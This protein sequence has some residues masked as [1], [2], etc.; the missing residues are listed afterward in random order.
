MI[1]RYFFCTGC[2]HFPPNTAQ[3]ML[4][5]IRDVWNVNNRIKLW[6]DIAYRG[7]IIFIEREKNIGC[8]V[9]IEYKNLTV[10]AAKTKR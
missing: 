6:F 8:S 1:S 10:L 7:L 2:D 3:C 9:M 4:N 5:V